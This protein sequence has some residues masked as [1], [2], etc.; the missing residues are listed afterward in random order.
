M[1]LE[2]EVLEQKPDV[3]EILKRYRQ[4]HAKDP[5]ETA[6]DQRQQELNWQFHTI[7]LY[8]VKAA[9]GVVGVQDGVLSCSSC[10]KTTYPVLDRNYPIEVCAKCHNGYFDELGKKAWV[11]EGKPNCTSCHV[12]HY[13]DKYRW[14]DLLIDK[15][16]GQRLQAMDDKA[17]E[18]I[19]KPPK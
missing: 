10:H 15:S 6:E 1:G 14:S 5:G 16:R 8:R 18:S 13:Y 9:P 3:V 4:Q 7:H 19:I 2:K 11:N 17:V 12:Q